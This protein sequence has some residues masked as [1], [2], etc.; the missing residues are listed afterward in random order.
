MNRLEKIAISIRHAPGLDRANWLWSAVRPA[1]DR[2]LTAITSSRGLDR[3]INGTDHFRLVPSSRGFVAEN[4]EPEV[5]RRVMDAVRS[6]DRI[7]E[8]GAHIGIYSIALAGRTGPGGLV[9]VFEPETSISATLEANIALNGLQDRIKLYRAAVGAKSGAVR[10]VG[11]RGYEGHVLRD[12]ESAREV[13]EVPMVT[14]DGV[15]EKERVDLLKIDVEGFE[16][17]VLEGARA[18]M[19]DA[20][21]RPR[22][23]LI[24]VHPYAWAAV[25][26]TSQSLLD[27]LRDC[28]YRAETLA[29]EPVC[30]I[31]EYGHI[32]AIP[33]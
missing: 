5:W 15:F 1:Y 9:N 20:Q 12:G 11:G 23:I 17:P 2:V 27:L 30:E 6:G 22:F 18:L 7:V 8:V 28:G 29:A 19:G 10:F 3:N 14:L 24:E 33:D 25:G 13:I 32:V 16:E 31:R 4:Y 26:T 21:R